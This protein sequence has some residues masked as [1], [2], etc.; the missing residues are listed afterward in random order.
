MWHFNTHRFLWLFLSHMFCAK[1]LCGCLLS[2]LG[3]VEIPGLQPFGM[4]QVMIFHA[5]CVSKFSSWINMRQLVLCHVSSNTWIVTIAGALCL[6]AFLPLV[7]AF[8]VPWQWC[9]VIPDNIQGSVMNIFRVFAAWLKQSWQSCHQSMLKFYEVTK[10]CRIC[11][12][13]DS[14]RTFHWLLCRSTARFPWTSLWWLGRNLLMCIRRGLSRCISSRS[15][16]SNDQQPSF[17][18]FTWDEDA[19]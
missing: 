3:F 8:G 18:S 4:G 5:I 10:K 2:L 1:D 13:P 7:G 17:L 14:W 12:F 11:T 19:V 16:L 6:F 15:S 9:K